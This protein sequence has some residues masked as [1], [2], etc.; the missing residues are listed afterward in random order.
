MSQ[1]E[2]MMFQSSHL[3]RRPVQIWNNYYLT[4]NPLERWRNNPWINHVHVTLEATM[5]NAASLSN[6]SVTIKQTG[7][8]SV[9]TEELSN[10]GRYTRILQLPW[11][12]CAKFPPLPSW[13]RAS[14]KWW[15]HAKEHEMDLFFASPIHCLQINISLVISMWKTCILAAMSACL[16]GCASSR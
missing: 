8:R 11:C 3:T 7:Y 13:D 6:A 10:W 2:N 12:G 16:L 4:M 9:V 1:A 5:H 15:Y 14:T